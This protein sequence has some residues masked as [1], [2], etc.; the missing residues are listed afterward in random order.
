MHMSIKAKEL[1]KRGNKIGKTE[2]M[3]RWFAYIGGVADELTQEDLLVG[4]E[5]VDDETKQLVDLRL[6]SK[7]FRFCRHFTSRKKTKVLV[8]VLFSDSKRLGFL[9]TYYG[10]MFRMGWCLD[11]KLDGLPANVEWSWELQNLPH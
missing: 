6:E 11:V 10:E 5:C 2:K 8:L 7:R 1:E 4:V 3:G 9:S